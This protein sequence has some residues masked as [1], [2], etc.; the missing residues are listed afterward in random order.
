MAKIASA[1]IQTATDIL[2]R[3]WNPSERFADGEQF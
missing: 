2:L 3:T 1:M